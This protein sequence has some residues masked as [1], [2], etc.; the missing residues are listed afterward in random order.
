MVRLLPNGHREFAVMSKSPG[1]FAFATFGQG[2]SA[3]IFD[4]E[5]PNLLPGAKPA[6]KVNIKKKPAAAMRKTVAP[7]QSLSEQEVQTE[8]ESESS[9]SEVPPTIHYPG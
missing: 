5:V 8:P 9:G 3:A 2:L 4:T 7:S 6:A 1:N